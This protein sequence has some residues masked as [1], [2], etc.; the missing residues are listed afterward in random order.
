MSSFQFC[1]TCFA[2]LYDQSTCGFCGQV[3][4][5]TVKESFVSVSPIVT[6]ENSDFEV[7][8][9][10]MTFQQWDEIG[11]GT[12]FV[13]RYSLLQFKQR[14]DEGYCYIAY[15]HW[16]GQHTF[17]TLWK[18][19]SLLSRYHQSIQYLST[20]YDASD[21]PIYSAFTPQEGLPIEQALQRLGWNSG[22]V[23]EVFRQV[24]QCAITAEANAYILPLFPP[25]QVW[26]RPD[27]IVEMSVQVGESMDT[28]TPMIRQLVS[29]LGWLY[30]PVESLDLLL[31]PLKIRPVVQRHWETPISVAQFWTEMNTCIHEKGWYRLNLKDR[32]WLLHNH[33]PNRLQLIDE[34][35]TVPSSVQL[36]IWNGVSG[37]WRLH[38]GKVVLQSC[39]EGL[40]EVGILDVND[41][42]E[43]VSVLESLVMNQ[44]VFIDTESLDSVLM[45]LRYGNRSTARIALASLIR[46][47]QHLSD[48]LNI[49]KTLYVVGDDGAAK[50]IIQIAL[51]KVD[52][53]REVLELSTV[54]RWWGGDVQL[55]KQVLKSHRQHLQTVWEYGEWIEGWMALIHSTPPASVLSSLQRLVDRLDVREKQEWHEYVSLHFGIVGDQLF[56]SVVLDE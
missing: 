34:T 22:R 14:L 48:W 29:L 7:A 30:D 16:V 13:G 23:W 27:G 53:L 9:L 35:I 20:V 32:T 3:L 44:T 54:I 24:C 17:V 4:S 45:H 18:S 8:G 1:P 12:L 46:R 5:T 6:M 37:S 52:F 19:S 47:T 40:F 42:G 21:G 36:C 51:G 41:G 25:E 49:A 39:L 43:S 31:F 10:P 26:I 28:S 55:T 50:D 38:E 33:A 56:S 2:E 11:K 15:D